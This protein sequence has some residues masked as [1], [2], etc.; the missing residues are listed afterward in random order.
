MPKNSDTTTRAIAAGVLSWLL[1]GAGHFYL[2]HRGIGVVMWVAVTFAFGTG[3]A[4]G[5]VKD[6]VNLRTNPW[7]F[8]AEIGVAGYTVPSW[9]AS[10]AVERHLARQSALGQQVNVAPYSSYYPESDVAT[11][12]L[13]TAGLLNLLV[14]LDAVARAQT[15]LPTFPRELAPPIAG[16]AG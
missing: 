3:L 6:S 15:G 14:I 1:P 2:G 5:G 7:L 12:Y 9:L 11:I 13:A 16:G 10:Q 4:F 8:V